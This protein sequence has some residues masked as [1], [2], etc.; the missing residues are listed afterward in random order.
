M[1]LFELFEKLGDRMENGTH[2]VL[3]ESDV[4]DEGLFYFVDPDQTIVNMDSFYESEVRQGWDWAIDNGLINRVPDA[5]GVGVDGFEL[6]PQLR[7][8]CIHR[9]VDWKNVVESESDE[10]DSDD[11]TDDLIDLDF[12]EVL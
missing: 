7:K 11:D 4:F 2:P 5:G 1:V 8:K 9:P 6:M 12:N 10:N 3:L